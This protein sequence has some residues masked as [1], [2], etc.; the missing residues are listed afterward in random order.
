MQQPSTYL[1]SL[2]NTEVSEDELKE[3]IRLLSNVKAKN[4]QLNAI[5]HLLRKVAVTPS[6]IVVLLESELV[7]NS[8]ALQYPIKKYV[9]IRHYKEA[10]EKSEHE[11]P[12]VTVMLLMASV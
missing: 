5:D 7:K 10:E 4:E 3:F 1:S 8:I 6:Q 11:S 12:W 2:K 9:S